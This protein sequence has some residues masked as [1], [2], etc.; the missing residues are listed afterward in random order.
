MS[1][2]RPKSLEILGFKKADLPDKICGQI[3]RAG[4]TVIQLTTQKVINEVL[5]V[6]RGIS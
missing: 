2:E 1:I 6:L 5:E 3:H 4:D